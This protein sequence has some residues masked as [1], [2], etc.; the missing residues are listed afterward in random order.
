[1]SS[2]DIFAGFIQNVAERSN[3][4]QQDLL[5]QE[6][7]RQQAAA[8]FWKSMADNPRVQPAWRDKYLQRYAM[9]LNSPPGKKLPKEASLDMLMEDFALPQRPGPQQAEAPA[10]VSPALGQTRVDIAAPNPPPGFTGEHPMM[11]QAQME[12]EALR[13][14]RAK[15]D[16]E[17]EYARKQFADQEQIRAMYRAPAVPPDV[18]ASSP[19]GIFNKFSGQI[20][21]PASPDENDRR[22]VD[23]KNYAQ[24]A[25]ETKAAGGKPMSFDAWLTMDANRRRSQTIVGG[26]AGPVQTR[27]QS[28]ASAYD[29][30]PTTK[31]YNEAAL[32]LANVNTI[33][34]GT[35]S[36]P[37]DMAIIFEFM[38]ALDPTSVVRESEYA[39][40]S[41]TGNIFAGWAARFNGALRPEGG[42]LSDQLKKDFQRVLQGRIQQATR[43]AQGIYNDFG[44]RIDRITQQPGT[45]T[46]YLTD[47]TTVF[48]I[49]VGQQDRAPSPP[50]GAT[51]SGGLSE[52]D[53]L[54]RLEEID[55]RLS[56]GAKAPAKTPPKGKKK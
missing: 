12:A 31:Q 13:P 32:R 8:G 44:R 47:Y 48:P 25:E 26:L 1:M 27:V 24:Y 20:L 36:G 45:G 46:G 14:L 55:R 18:Y 33:L 10:A 3:K 16:L 29:N 40:A 7:A 19:L 22:T 9:I 51:P 28:L 43:Q 39:T 30:H 54:Q 50:S 15:L 38:R 52:A 2:R 5:Q 17:T 42:F 35:W 11:G 53:V 41:K 34:Q 56:Q 6:M 49:D 37:G 23:Q 21:H 4:Q